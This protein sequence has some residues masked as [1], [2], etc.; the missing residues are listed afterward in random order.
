MHTDAL[1]V[2]RGTVRVQT[3]ALN[4]TINRAPRKCIEIRIHTSAKMATP[5]FPFP[6]LNAASTSLGL[7][8]SSRLNN[9][10]RLTSMLMGQ[11]SRKRST[12]ASFSQ[13]NASSVFLQKYT[14]TKQQ[15]TSSNYFFSNQGG[16][17]TYSLVTV[18]VKQQNDL[19][20]KNM[21]CFA[22]FFQLQADSAA[23]E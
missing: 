5:P 12:S 19:R 9:R 18:R 13:T 20:Q 7:F 16:A 2:L 10:A 11:R 8:F 4:K 3:E 23:G 1:T 6:P 22:A 15:L 17:L 21:C 14:R